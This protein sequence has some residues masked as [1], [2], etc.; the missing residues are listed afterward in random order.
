MVDKTL[1]LRKLAELEKYLGQIREFSTVS[2]EQYSSDW[3]IWGS[4]LEN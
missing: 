3:E 2:A 4:G 1:L